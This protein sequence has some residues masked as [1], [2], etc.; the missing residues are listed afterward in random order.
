ML[1]AM[2]LLF[3]PVVYAE[4]FIPA[5]S[6]GVVPTDQNLAPPATVLVELED[7]RY[8]RAGVSEDGLLVELSPEEGVVLEPLF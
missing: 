4:I 7:V 6:N 5:N 3:V 2:V 8:N 1:I